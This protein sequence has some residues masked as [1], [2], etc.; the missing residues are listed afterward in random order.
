MNFTFLP[1]IVIALSDLALKYNKEAIFLKKI[2]K[3]Q[4]LGLGFLST[5]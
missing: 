4:T 2:K 5:K 3:T 1:H